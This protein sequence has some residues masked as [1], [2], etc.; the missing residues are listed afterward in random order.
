MYTWTQDPYLVEVAINTLPCKG[1][2]DPENEICKGCPCQEHCQSH[3]QTMLMEFAGLKPIK[4]T[5]EEEVDQVDP[6]DP[7]MKVELDNLKESKALV[8]MCCH[9]CNQTIATGD[10]YMWKYQEVECY[11]MSCHEKAKVAQNK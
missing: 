11:C 5:K 9:C 4:R 1:G 3:Q 10:L 8:A 2:H 7:L 6:N